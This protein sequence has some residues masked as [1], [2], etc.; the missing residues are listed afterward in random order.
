[1]RDLG[2]ELRHGDIL[3]GQQVAL[4]GQ[5]PIGYLAMALISGTSE[6]GQHDG[7]PAVDAYE[8]SFLGP[9]GAPSTRRYALAGEDIA[10]TLR[11]GRLTYKLRAV[12]AFL[13]RFGRIDDVT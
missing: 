5:S 8:S 4:A 7:H 11:V 2:H 1:L 9:D 12:R 10:A 13:I 3:A 6:S